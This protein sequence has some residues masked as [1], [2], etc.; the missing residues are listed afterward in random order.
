M[1]QCYV[2]GKTTT[3]GNKRSHALNA[4]RRM[5]KANLNTQME[6]N[7]HRYPEYKDNTFGIGDYRITMNP[8]YA[9]DKSHIKKIS[10]RV[11]KIS[12]R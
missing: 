8:K 2:T 1:A 6:L 12:I 5:W 9:L 3:F 10:F 11:E 4:T 7:M